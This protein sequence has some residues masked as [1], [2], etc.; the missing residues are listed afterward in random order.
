MRDDLT[1]TKASQEVSRQTSEARRRG[2]NT[3]KVPKE[4]TVNQ[5]TYILQNCPS[6]SL[7]KERNS[8][9]GYNMDESGGHYAK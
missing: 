7:E 6:N 9:T 8:D 3:F 1:H 4:K 2:T 5:E